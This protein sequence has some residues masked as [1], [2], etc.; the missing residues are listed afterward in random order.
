[1]TL[2]I[3]G[4]TG[5]GVWPA[6]TLEGARGCLG[7]PVDGVEIDVQLTVDGHVVAHHDYRLNRHAT[8][9]VDTWLDERGPALKS[10]TLDELRRYDVGALRPGSAYAE[11]YPAR[12]SI[13][14]VRIPTLRELLDLLKGAPGPRRWIYVEIKTDP[15]S[16]ADAPD[17]LAVTEAVLSDLAAADWTDRAKIIAFD[18][19][20][21]RLAR[22]RA[23]IATA[24]LT[25]PSAMAGSV[26]LAD[27]GSSPWL[28]GHD[29]HRFGGSQLAAIAA[30]GGM[31]WSPHVADVTDEALEAARA[32]GLKVG[33]WGVSSA[34]DIGRLIDAGVWSVTVSGP[35]WGRAPLDVAGAPTP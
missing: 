6:N 4:A 7:A 8:R 31:E 11:R 13:D 25:I 24:H 12:L 21:L 19:R 2:I 18:W 34:A 3:A 26:R 9:L 14:G 17:P 15:Q 35:A 29:P 28:D 22:E 33:P 5:Y 27:D 23:P 30:H 32:L 16:P 20:V 10:L 1:M